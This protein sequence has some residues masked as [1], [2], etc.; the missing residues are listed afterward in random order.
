MCSSPSSLI[1]L[2]DPEIVHFNWRYKGRKNSERL[3]RLALQANGL[4]LYQP[5]PSGGNAIENRKE[6]PE[7]AIEILHIFQPLVAQ[8]HV[9]VSPDE[10][11]S[12]GAGRVPEILNHAPHHG[13]HDF[14]SLRS[15]LQNPIPLLRRSRQVG[16]I[17][18]V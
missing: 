18:V 2:E 16:D 8:G 14:R 9:D 10:G 17:V 13:W 4:V 7:C 1:E 6:W 3:P 11:V 15:R 12:R 5:V